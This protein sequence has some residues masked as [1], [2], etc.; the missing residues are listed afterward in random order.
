MSVKINVG[1]SIEPVQCEWCLGITC[2][3]L[4]IEVHK[5]NGEFD[6]DVAICPDCAEEVG[7]ATNKYLGI[8]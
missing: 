7:K 5:Q 1:D 4:E 2:L 3:W 8:K 6:Y